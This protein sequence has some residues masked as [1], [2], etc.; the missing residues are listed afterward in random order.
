[1]VNSA[2]DYDGNI[3]IVDDISTPENIHP[4]RTF[5]TE[6]STVINTTIDTT[7]EYATQSDDIL[8]GSREDN[9]ILT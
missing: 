7:L 1:M 2:P 5:I 8:M 6:G 4:E 3:N 9:I